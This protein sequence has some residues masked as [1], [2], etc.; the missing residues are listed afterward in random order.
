MNLGVCLSRP[1]CLPSCGAA[2]VCAVDE[3]QLHRSAEVTHDCC[4]CRRWPAPSTGRCCCAAR[5]LCRLRSAN[6]QTRH[7]PPPLPLLRLRC[8][9][10]LHQ[11]RV[12]ASPGGGASRL[13]CRFAENC[14]STTASVS[15][16]PA[17]ELSPDAPSQQ[18]H[19]TGC[20]QV[21]VRR[22]DTLLQA[23]GRDIAAIQAD[24][25]ATVRSVL[26]G[27][28]SADAPLMAAGLDSLGALPSTNVNIAI[29][30][31]PA[32]QRPRDRCIPDHLAITP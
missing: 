12:R 22:N 14:I 11:H 6:T 7:L 29:I 32:P 31:L 23:P 24:V 20:C 3:Q 10:N 9:S 16:L 13:P 8:R 18:Q 1:A 15:L 19:H 21:C 17:A 28:V 25:A 27:D 26:G 2:V 30:L 5:P 4:C